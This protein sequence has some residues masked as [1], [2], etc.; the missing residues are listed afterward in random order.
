MAVHAAARQSVGVAKVAQILEAE[1]G[2]LFEWPNA[3]TSISF[4]RKAVSSAVPRHGWI[5]E[6]THDCHLRDDWFV[7]VLG[8]VLKK[9]AK[10]VYR[11]TRDKFMLV[12]SSLLFQNNVIP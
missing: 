10:G 8:L 9:R 3:S 1:I 11:K 5:P 7:I 12:V 2:R 4:Q 6:V